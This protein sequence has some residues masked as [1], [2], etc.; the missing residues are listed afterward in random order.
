[1]LH[2]AQLEQGVVYPW[3]VASK[4]LWKKIKCGSCSNLN[5]SLVA[6]I[7]LV[8]RFRA[9]KPLWM[10][11]RRAATFQCTCT[12]PLV[13]RCCWFHLLF[14]MKRN[15]PH[16]DSWKGLQFRHIEIESELWFALDL[17]L[18]EAVSNGPQFTCANH[19]FEMISLLPIFSLME[20][21]SAAA[22]ALGA[23]SGRWSFECGTVPS[24][25]RWSW[26]MDSLNGS[27]QS[28]Q[29]GMHVGGPQ[30]D[31]QDLQSF[32]KESDMCPLSSSFQYYSSIILKNI[33]KHFHYL[34]SLRGTQEVAWSPR[35]CSRWGPGGC[36]GCPKGPGDKRAE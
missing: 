12:T 15:D 35:C 18:K 10:H 13:V 34:Q 1:M 17:S 11:W 19:Y 29:L 24:S 25:S 30:A 28:L 31:C 6:N 3:F 9:R 20:A 16:Q 4:F 23:P 2:P 5:W 7:L 21:T 8:E 32:W 36:S 22:A 27:K 33:Q 26:G 14:G